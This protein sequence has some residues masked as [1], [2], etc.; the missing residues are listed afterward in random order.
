MMYEGT[1]DFLR[2]YVRMC[3][4]PEET[5]K[6]EVKEKALPKYLPAFE[7]VRLKHYTFDRMS[8]YGWNKNIR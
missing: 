5:V 7:K 4:D 6:A 8:L 3:F 2:A 1:R